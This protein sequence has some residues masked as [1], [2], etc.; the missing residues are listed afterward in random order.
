MDR[1]DR[2]IEASLRVAGGMDVDDA[3]D[4]Y[5][6]TADELLTHLDNMVDFD[7]GEDFYADI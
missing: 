7:G 4:Q 6:L 1:L 5:E 2:L 3:A